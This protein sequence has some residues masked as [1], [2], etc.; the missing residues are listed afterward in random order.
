MGISST[1]QLQ[2][3][4]NQATTKIEHANFTQASLHKPGTGKNPNIN[5]EMQR[6]LCCNQ[7]TNVE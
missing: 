1:E 7:G 3:Q 5:G 2:N 6:D 4:E